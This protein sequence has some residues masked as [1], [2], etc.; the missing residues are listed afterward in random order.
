VKFGPE[1]AKRLRRNHQG[2]G[3]TLEINLSVLG[4]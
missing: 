4:D 1:F 3:D 2:Y